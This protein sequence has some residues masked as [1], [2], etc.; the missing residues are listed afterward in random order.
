MA[1]GN[2]L[3]TVL[4]VALVVGVTE[5][6]LHPKKKKKKYPSIIHQIP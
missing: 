2:L 6:L 1:N 4:G 5:S 3:G